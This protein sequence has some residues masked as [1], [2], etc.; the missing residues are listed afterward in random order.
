M[1]SSSDSR[2]SLQGI[3][4]DHQ[5]SL[6]TAACGCVPTLLLH[7]ATVVTLRSRGPGPSWTPLFFRQSSSTAGPPAS[8]RYHN[9][10]LSGILL[11]RS[12][13]TF[14]HTWLNLWYRVVLVWEVSLNSDICPPSC[15]HSLPYHRRVR[16]AQHCRITTA[17][18]MPL[19]ARRD[20]LTAESMISPLR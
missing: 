16:L 3:Q 1:T 6:H 7:L 13:P 4:L 2:N 9:I 20:K 5:P 12:I 19:A 11:P 18:H 8:S 17:I 14:T 15:L 10:S